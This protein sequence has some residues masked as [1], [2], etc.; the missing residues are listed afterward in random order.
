MAITTERTPLIGSQDG[1]EPEEIA[2]TEIE[3]NLVGQ[4][5]DVP[6]MT[7][8]KWRKILGILLALTGEFLSYPNNVNTNYL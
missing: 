2:E 1:A 6:S 8:P 7:S 3:S 4:A 5:E